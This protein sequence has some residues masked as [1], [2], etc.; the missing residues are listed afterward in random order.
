MKI[1]LSLIIIFSLLFS[2]GY[3]DNYFKKNN[4]QEFNSKRELV[5]KERDEF[6]KDI[7]SLYNTFKKFIL[8]TPINSYLDKIEKIIEDANKIEKE[9]AIRY[10]QIENQELLEEFKQQQ[11]EQQKNSDN[12]NDSNIKVSN[13]QIKGTQ[14]TSNDNIGLSSTTTTL[15]DLLFDSLGLNS[16]K[17]QKL[18]ISLSLGA[19]GNRSPQDNQRQQ[20]QHHHQHQRQ[21]QEQQQNNEEFV[22]QTPE[23]TSRQ[24]PTLQQLQEEQAR[25]QE[26]QEQQQ[27]QQQQQ[28]NPKET[29]QQ[30]ELQIQQNQQWLQEQLTRQQEELKLQQEELKRQQEIDH[31]RRL[32]FEQELEKFKK[33]QAERD[34][35]DQKEKQEREAREQKE[36]QEREEKEKQEK[37][38]KERK[39]K[40]E[41][42]RKEKEEKERKEKEEKDKQ[43]QNSSPAFS[44][45]DVN[46]GGASDGGIVIHV[47]EPSSEG[48]SDSLADEILG[49]FN[50]L[51]HD[52][53]PSRNQPKEDSFDNIPNTEDTSNPELSPI[54]NKKKIIEK[55]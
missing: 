37:E 36:K 22:T 54:L 27:Q 9:Q 3:C 28:Q 43:R 8:E 5:E 10:Q 23:Q 2:I 33:D 20:Q 12:N 55:I 44:S 24:H 14:S 51:I 19:G 38:E 45:N 46:T 52:R 32:E 1:L 50:H 40:E 15:E 6:N 47:R 16:E 39:E 4:D 53:I 41:K 35:R 17:M 48:I 7:E 21:Q 34:A 29:R 49:F 42:E 25:L 18:L 13:K 30:E 11:K 31:Q 26:L